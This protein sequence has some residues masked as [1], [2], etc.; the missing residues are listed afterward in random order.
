MPT[1][2]LRRLRAITL[3]LPFL[4]AAPLA[5]QQV[6]MPKTGVVSTST[7]GFTVVHAVRINAAP[8]RVYEALTTQVGKWWNPDHSYSKNS[9]NLSMAPKAGGCFCE[10]LPNGGSVEHMR[11]VMVMP[12]RLLRLD[13]GLGPLQSLGVGAHMTWEFAADGNATKLTMT[14]VVGGYMDGGLDKMSAPVS[15]MLQETIGRLQRFIETGAPV[16]K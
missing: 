5:A 16:A 11:V 6:A 7:N 2:T 4:T 13:G 12:N 8:S 15:G 1:T 10:T 9:E 14:Y 3:A